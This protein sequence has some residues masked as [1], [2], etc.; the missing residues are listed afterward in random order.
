MKAFAITCKILAGII[1]VGIASLK[2]GSDITGRHSSD[3]RWVFLELVLLLVL[4]FLAVAP[5]RWFVVS[6]RA[7]A[8]SLFFALFPFCVVVAYNWIV[9]PIHFGWGFFS[10]RRSSKRRYYFWPF[11]HF[12]CIE[13]LAAAERREC[14]VCLTHHEAV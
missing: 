4:A 3:Y 11:A 14:H 6:R 5:N 13:L 2:I 10:A 1:W 12:A 9:T 8:T 7:F